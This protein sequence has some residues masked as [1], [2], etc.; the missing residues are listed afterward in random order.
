MSEFQYTCEDCGARTSDP[1]VSTIGL[2]K[3][4]ARCAKCYVA[5]MKRITQNKKETK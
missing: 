3:M 2:P 1:F 4:V 5:A